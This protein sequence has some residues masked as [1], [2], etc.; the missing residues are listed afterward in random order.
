MLFFTL[1]ISALSFGCDK[2]DKQDA[3]PD[4]QLDCSTIVCL[5]NN[6]LF[7]FKVVDRNTGADL[8]GGPSPKY[9]SSDIALYADIAATQSIPLTYDGSLFKTNLAQ[10]DMYLVVDGSASY[11]V[12]ATFR[13]IDCC[14]SR[15]RKLHVNNVELCT[16]C[17]DAVSI[18]VE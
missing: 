9:N 14:T 15:V 1:I 4:P 5:L 16:C 17:A 13:K 3:C 18:P 10:S 6:N 12:K 7:D 8:V 2:N 11:K